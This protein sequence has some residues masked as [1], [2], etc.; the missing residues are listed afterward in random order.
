[1]AG[2]NKV[3]LVGRLGHNPEI[4][5][6]PDGLAVAKISLATSEKWK[7]KN[8]GEEKEK[9]EWHKVIVFGK[10]AEI[11]AE[12]LSK[13]CMAYFEGKLGTRK[14]EDKNGNTRYTTEITAYQMQILEWNKNGEDQEGDEPPF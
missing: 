9:T 1:M 11:C 12:Y 7:D 5:Y 13:G 4:S 10:L 6:T 8:T 2:I 3:I 14:W